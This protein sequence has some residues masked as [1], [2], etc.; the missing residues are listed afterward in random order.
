MAILRIA[1]AVVAVLTAVGVSCSIEGRAGVVEL[2]ADNGLH[3]QKQGRRS[4][5]LQSTALREKLSP[6]QPGR[7]RSTDSNWGVKG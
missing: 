6:G 2:R 4:R 3:S 1:S 7:S 5:Y